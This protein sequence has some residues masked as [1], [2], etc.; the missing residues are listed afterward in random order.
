MAGMRD[1]LIHKYDD[2]DFTVVWKT[3]IQ[4]VPTLKKQIE[5]LLKKEKE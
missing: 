5:Q 2:R 3:A 4:F 1:I